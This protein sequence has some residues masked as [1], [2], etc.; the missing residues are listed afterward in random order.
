MVKFQLVLFAALIGLLNALI[1]HPGLRR[2]L[3]LDS[4]RFKIK[5]R[6]LKRALLLEIGTL[7]IVM[8]FAAFLS[9]AEPAR[10]PEFSP[11]NQATTASNASYSAAVNDLIVSFSVKP[12]R[13]GRNFVDLNIFNTRRPAPAPFAKV[14]L[15]LTSPN[16]QEN[17]VELPSDGNGHY[18]LSGDQLQNA[19]DW[20]IGVAIERSNLPIAQT[21]FAWKVLATQE[22]GSRRPVVFSNQPL[23]PWFNLA[24]GLILL[25]GSLFWLIWRLAGKR[26]LAHPI[27]ILITFVAIKRN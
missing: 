21:S 12:N 3:H 7:G 19:G 26:F 15:M 1:L 2:W 20:Q 9:G 24:A 18:Q 23:Q 10:G 27:N 16:G 22:T 8:G 5:P 14:R 4:S 6:F 25:A 13:P 11:F 17:L